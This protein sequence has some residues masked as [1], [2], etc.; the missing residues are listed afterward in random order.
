MEQ[1]ATAGQVGQLQIGDAL[2]RVGGGLR[3]AEPDERHQRRRRDRQG[4]VEACISIRGPV[5]GA[6]RFSAGDQ[7]ARPLRGCLLGILQGA[8]RLLELNVSRSGPALPD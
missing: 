6:K 4:C 5:L 3:H 7:E 1:L 2:H 8:E